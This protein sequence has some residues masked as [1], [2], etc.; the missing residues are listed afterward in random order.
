LHIV[1]N[2]GRVF[3]VHD[4]NLVVI[5]TSRRGEMAD[6]RDLKSLVPRGTCGF[7]SR[8]RQDPMATTENT[9]DTEGGAGKEL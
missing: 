7:E 3:H 9:E 1:L 6:A 5:R 2:E 8:R 4:Y